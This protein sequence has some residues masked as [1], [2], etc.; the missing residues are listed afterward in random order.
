[1]FLA[2]FLFFALARGEGGVF[3]DTL[4]VGRKFA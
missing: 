3:D 2:D 4:P 1:L